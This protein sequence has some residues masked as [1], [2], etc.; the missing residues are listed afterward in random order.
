M[1]DLSAG[2][3]VPVPTIKYYLREGLLPP[4]RPLA[5]NQAEYGPA[6]VRRLKLVRALADYGG[7]SIAAIA[8]LVRHL[9]DPGVAGGTLLAEAQPAVTPP[10]EPG[11]GAGAGRARRHVADL[12]AR[13]GWDRLAAH[14]SAATL[15]GVLASLLELG[16]DDVLDRMDDYAAAAEAAAATDVRILGDVSDRERA[17]EVVVLGTLLGDT[18]IAALR[19]LAQAHLA[20][21]ACTG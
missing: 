12:L 15:T 3:G 18:L 9:D 4:G 13:K 21:E 5:R 11:G 10:P 1:A 17:V 6:H 16:L 2:T 19:R 14:P 7:L 8:G 20:G